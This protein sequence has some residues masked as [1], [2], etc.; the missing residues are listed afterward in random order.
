MLL[1]MDY[2]LFIKQKRGVI[3]SPLLFG[4]C[5]RNLIEHVSEFAEDLFFHRLARLEIG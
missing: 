1:L 2:M 5:I 4:F 3:H